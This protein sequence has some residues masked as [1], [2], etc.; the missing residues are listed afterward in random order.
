MQHVN[1]KK[2]CRK[3]QNVKNEDSYKTSELTI[4]CD[5]SPLFGHGSLHRPSLNYQ[6]YFFRRCCL[7]QLHKD[8]RDL[9]QEKKSA[10]LFG[11]VALPAIILAESCPGSPLR[12]LRS[13]GMHNVMRSS[14]QKK[15]KKKSWKWCQESNS[16]CYCRSKYGVMGMCIK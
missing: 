12:S 11:G 4:L 1:H 9:D 5:R 8:L 13:T 7:H 6:R 16:F 3:S 2:P 14:A 10:H 15:K